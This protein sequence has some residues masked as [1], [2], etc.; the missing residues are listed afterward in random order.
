MGLKKL[1]HQ[2][3]HPCTVPC[4][5]I[6]C[7]VEGQDPVAKEFSVSIPSCSLSVIQFT[8]PSNSS[9][10]LGPPCLPEEHRQQIRCA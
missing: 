2:L 5:V 8:F 6:D 7:E 3:I 1:V 4:R 10:T 9:S